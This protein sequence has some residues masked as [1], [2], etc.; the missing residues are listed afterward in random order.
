LTGYA[1]P[2]GTK[3]FNQELAQKRVA[4]V[5]RYLVDNGVSADRIST[6]VYGATKATAKGMGQAKLQLDRKVIGNFT[7][8][9]E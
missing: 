4:T 2:R 1:D 8:V 6:E 9:A 5:Q 3:A 7:T